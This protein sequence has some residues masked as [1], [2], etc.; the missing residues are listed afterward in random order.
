MAHGKRLQ[1][2]IWESRASRDL[3]CPAGQALSFLDEPADATLE[4]TLRELGVMQPVRLYSGRGGIGAVLSQVG[5]VLLRS[6]FV[7]FLDARAP[8]IGEG[9][10]R[11]LVVAL[12]G[13]DLAVLRGNSAALAARGALLTAAT[14]GGWARR[15]PDLFELGCALAAKSQPSLRMVEI[16][17]HAS[18]E[19][20]LASVADAWEAIN[21]RRLARALDLVG[22]GLALSNPARFALQGKLT[23]GRHV[24]IGE[25]VT[26]RGNV[27]LG[28]N[29]VVGP[30]CLLEN[31]SVG[32]G[33][34]I[35]EFT[36]LSDAV[37]G[38]GC[39]VGPFARI[40]PGT[41]LGDG[42]QIGNYVEIKGSTLGRNCRINHHNFIGD[43]T[44][45]HDVTIGAG[46]ITCNY[47]GIKSQPT[48]I[49][50][51][52]FVGSGVMI[53]APVR[54]GRNA[55]VAAGTTLVKNAAANS[56][57]LARV[58]QSSVRGWA[59]KTHPSKT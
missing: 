47:D 11:K 3:L 9:V 17:E 59:K 50:D 20:V 35:K 25:D 6:H 37:I 27:T 32:S 8:F 18:H 4:A 39:R 15:A 16:E 34:R 43:A 46:T 44:I 1:G 51:K 12:R 54:I 13:A 36:L 52:A 2:V 57:T 14:R 56:L 49:A 29:V 53:V 22:Q 55:F 24:A 31:V 23:F 21:A 33:S 26:I 5:P 7:L 40:R 41:R 48:L 30:H 42:G 10:L 45:G 28:D 19:R 58:K 38:R